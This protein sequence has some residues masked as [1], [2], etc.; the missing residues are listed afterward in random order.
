MIR[1]SIIY[2]CFGVEILPLI[3]HEHKKTNFVDKLLENV[4]N[5][6]VHTSDIRGAG[7]DANVFMVL[8]GDKGKSEEIPL[9]NKTDNF[10]R[11]NVDKLKVEIKEVG[12]PYKLRIWH[13]NSKMYADW[14][15]EKVRLF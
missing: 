12:T 15:L 8:Y 6:A 11:G 2:S 10:E 3:T 1:A 5:V 13:D 4:W 7:T 14:H 9:R